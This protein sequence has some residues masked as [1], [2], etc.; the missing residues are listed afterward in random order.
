MLKIAINTQKSENV[1]LSV[2][3]DSGLFTIFF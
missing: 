2:S 3:D 1:S